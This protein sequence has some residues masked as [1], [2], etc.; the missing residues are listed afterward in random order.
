MRA[1]ILGSGLMSG[2]L[3]MSTRTLAVYARDYTA[4]LVKA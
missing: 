2:K 4:D 3:G 1:S